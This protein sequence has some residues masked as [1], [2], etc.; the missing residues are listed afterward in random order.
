MATWITN[1]IACLGLD[2]AS[3]EPYII[4]VLYDQNLSEEDK[5]ATIYECLEANCELENI[6][7]QDAVAD[8]F[9]Q[10]HQDGLFW[11]QAPMYQSPLSALDYSS[12]FAAAATPT[13]PRSRAVRITRPDDDDKDK[14]GSSNNQTPLEK[15]IESDRPVETW[16]RI[17]DDQEEEDD[18]TNGGHGL[19][20][21]ANGYS[22]PQD[23][24][25]DRDS[26]DPFDDDEFNPFAP[27]SSSDI[28]VLN[29]A[30]QQ[31]N[32]SA[33]YPP[34]ILYGQDSEYGAYEDD[35][36][37][38]MTP[39]EMLLLV[40]S[41][42]TPEKIENA[43]ELSGYDMD[44]TLERI[45]DEKSAHKNA[46][47]QFIPVGD[48]RSTQTCRHFLQGNCFRKDC[49]YSHDL[50]QMV[51]KFWL[52]GQC[53][54][55]EGCE[56]NHYLDATR[57]KESTKTSPVPKQEPPKMDDSDFPSLSATVS[58]SGK[59][60]GKAANGSKKSN[61]QQLKQES[62]SKVT[63]SVD[64]LAEQLEDKVKVT[65]PTVSYSAT[66]AAV[67]SKPVTPLQ[68]TSTAV[69]TDQERKDFKRSI[70]PTSI[71]WLETGSAINSHYLEARSKAIEYARARNRCFEKASA[72]Y[73]KNDRAGAMRLS[74]Q[75]REYNDLMMSVHREASRRIFESRN[76][77][78]IKTTVKG[79]TWI[80]LHGLHKDESLAFLDEFME[81][82]E[83]EKYTG[84]VYV[85][86]GRGTHSAGRAKLKPAVMDWLD[87]W[88]YLW[89]EL[90]IDRLDG[91]VIAIN[92]KEGKA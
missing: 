28:E 50:D 22:H 26:L 79:E 30:R 40:I 14:N 57:I 10:Y 73:I 90:K 75:G 24:L 72:A 85:V 3:F 35:L 54:K 15:E 9:A 63:T 49:W 39:L 19:D 86:T 61:G 11:L 8:L 60:A 51:C 17:D 59:G 74:M 62:A 7:L 52:K 37:V 43:F 23:L 1:Y 46:L 13:P 67:A 41:D 66:A 47:A 69:A 92:V 80:D 34:P 21:V 55:G 16:A 84:M 25:E 42:T 78:I 12:Q 88:G 44:A 89:E 45:M 68:R 5:T 70:A 31:P 29:G 82:L 65:L 27:P 71:P 6:N 64:A 77:T 87:S 2:V 81:K 36:D 20:H 38:D 32:Y 91:G 18:A 53:F 58:K 33:Q 83:M 48:V 56:F 76:Q 4:Q